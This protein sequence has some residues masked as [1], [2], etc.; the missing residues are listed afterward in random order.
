MPAETFTATTKLTFHHHFDSEKTGLVV[1]GRGY[2]YIALVQKG[3]DLYLQQVTCNKAENGAKEEVIQE[4]KMDQNTC[5]LQVKVAEDGIC[6]FA[7]STDG[8]RF[9]DLGKTFQAREG[10]WIGAKVGLFSNRDTHNNDGGYT[11]YDWFRITK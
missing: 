7:Y 9:K 6:Q 3:E 2:A 1:M 4:I 5:Q 11:N 10:K 8:K